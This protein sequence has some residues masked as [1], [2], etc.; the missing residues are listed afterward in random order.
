MLQ[1]SSVDYKVQSRYCLIWTTHS[2]YEFWRYLEHIEK[3]NK[4]EC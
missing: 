1:V 4:A 2:K 3:R